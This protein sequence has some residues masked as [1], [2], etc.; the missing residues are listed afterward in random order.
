MWP[1]LV[2]LPDLL[3]LPPLLLEPLAQ[4]LA[5]A[6]AVSM[7][8]FAARSTAEVS[9]RKLQQLL[10]VTEAELAANV[11]ISKHLLPLLQQ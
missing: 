9:I 4:E 6:A 3:L 7:M 8:T 11:I 2:V 1:T 10:Q 5:A